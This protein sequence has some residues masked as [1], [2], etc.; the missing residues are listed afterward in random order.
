[1]SKHAKRMLPL[2]AFWLVWLLVAHA[3]DLFWL[4]MPNIFVRQIPSMPRSALPLPEALKTIL[5]SQQSV[6]QLRE[7]SALVIDAVKAPLQPLAIATVIGLLLAMGG[8]FLA[9]TAWLLKGARIGAREGPA[10]GRILAF[11]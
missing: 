4:I 10:V 1:M 11:S 3:F 7:G 5:E 2:F 8:L 6:Y 9:N